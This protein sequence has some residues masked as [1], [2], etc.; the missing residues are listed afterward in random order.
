MTDD[1]VV[2][3]EAQ[4]S[5]GHVQIEVAPDDRAEDQEHEAGRNQQDSFETC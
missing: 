1:D 4:Q 2:R 3:V 5:G